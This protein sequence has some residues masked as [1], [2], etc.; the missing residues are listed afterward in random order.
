MHLRG[1]KDSTAVC[2]LCHDERR[3]VNNAIRAP[4][5][6]AVFFH[7]H[8]AHCTGVTPQTRMVLH[9]TLGQAA[10]TTGEEGDKGS[11]KQLPL[12]LLPG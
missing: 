6:V 8:V 11:R 7:C 4:L 5:H 1:A 3:M 2:R 10:F 9:S 12:R